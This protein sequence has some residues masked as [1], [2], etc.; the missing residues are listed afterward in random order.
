MESFDS[1]NDALA[2]LSTEY[3]ETG[4]NDKRQYVLRYCRLHYGR[5]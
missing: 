1:I 5:I 2:D 3:A 4:S